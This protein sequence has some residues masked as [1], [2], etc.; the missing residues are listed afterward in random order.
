MGPQLRSEAGASRMQQSSGF[1]LRV[2]TLGYWH[3]ETIYVW[4][5]FLS[6]QS[7]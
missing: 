3:F 6:W 5:W 7:L 2:W 1:G 4:N